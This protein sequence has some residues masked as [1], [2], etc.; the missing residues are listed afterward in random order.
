MQ[1]EYTTYLVTGW[2]W[3]VALPICAMVFTVFGIVI[4]VVMS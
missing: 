2:R 3:C 4:G 1:R